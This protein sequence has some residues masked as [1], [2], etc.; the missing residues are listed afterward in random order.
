M[1]LLNTVVNDTLSLA[2]DA[3]ALAMA[4][5]YNLHDLVVM[6]DSMFVETS[7]NTDTVSI[8]D[9]LVISKG[10][11]IAVSDS[12]ATSDVVAKGFVRWTTLGDS[13]VS[14]DQV[15]LQAQ[16]AKSLTDLAVV[17]DTIHTWKGTDSVLTA[18]LN[19]SADLRAVLMTKKAPGIP[20]GMPARAQVLPKQA[21]VRTEHFVVN[22]NPP[23]NREG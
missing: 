17:G 14:A 23:R 18:T 15:S 21:P 4:F 11:G 9:S 19:G 1:A 8:S 2:P 22:P 16:Y 7:F 13:V 5:Q 3:V 12:V 10:F 6:G 20:L